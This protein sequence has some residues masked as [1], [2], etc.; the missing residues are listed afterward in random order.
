[1]FTG[2]DE[3]DW[4]SLRHANGSAE[5]VPGWLRGLASAEPGERAAALDGMYGAVHHDGRVYDSTLAC[6]PFLLALAADERVRE[7]GGLVELLVSIGTGE[8]SGAQPGAGGVSAVRAGAEVFV[9][10]AGD[11]DA[12]VRRAAAAAVVRFLDEPARVLGLVRERLM[13]ER[14]DRIVIALID[15]LGHFARRGPGQC[16]GA[17]ELLAAQSGPPYG[18]GPRL[19][20]LGQLA[21]CAPERLP[22]DLVAVVLGLLRE[23]SAR[24]RRCPIPSPAAADAPS[25][26]DRLRRLRPSD[27]E[28]TRLLRTLHTALDDRL[29]DRI[30]L[31]HGQLTSPEPTDRCNAVL[32]S[33]ALFR[34]WRGGHDA[35][36][37]SIGERLRSREGEA[38]EDEGRLRDAAVSVLDDLFTLAAPAADDLHALVA[39]RPDLW[40][41]RWRREAPTLGGPLRALARSGDPR[42]APVLAEVLAGPVLP[43]DLG[44]VVADLGASAAPLAPD[45]RHAL[46]AVPLG[47]P[48]TATRAAALL[49]AVRA[50]RDA[51][52]V[53]GV[54]RLLS[55]AGLGHGDDRC[56][57]AAIE[58]LGAIGSAARAAVPAL[59]AALEGEQ[60]LAAADALW[61]VEGDASVVLPVLLRGSTHADS[62]Y[63]THAARTLALLGPAARPALP[64]LRRMTQAHTAP[65]RTAA[66]CAVS[67]ITGEADASVA[68]V[69]RSAWAEHPR[70]RVGIAAC[71][72]ALG[73]AA[74]PL[75]D[76]A[77]TELAAP[78]RHTAQP[79]GQGSPGHGSHDIPRDEELL[80]V[81]GRVTA[82]T[83]A[84]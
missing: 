35:T 41:R 74:A 8:G 46:A 48:D 73:P 36:V 6:V 2:I 5:D 24:R 42:A 63:R 70:T 11:P 54:L 33:A 78:R 14:D 50:L 68:A 26:V 52:A 44:R 13:V 80:R 10:L 45:L 3:V 55:D 58:T 65:E 62:R 60:A 53:P 47:S 37:A 29:S 82:T 79:G 71:L 23:R 40:L 16:A 30:A 28:G 12:A 81:C 77:T 61:S 69:L 39:A 67:R 22:A 64:T 56:A 31:L 4:T 75:R 83:T 7:R 1:M 21:A 9:R 43:R 20:A 51:E 15:G 76:L 66:A 34:E 57:R 59:H 17:V 25:L 27:E 49:P 38:Q 84:S 32:L 19:A 18:P 72:G